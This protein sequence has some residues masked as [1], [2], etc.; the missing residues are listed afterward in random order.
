MAGER[1]KGC[2]PARQIPRTSHRPRTCN[3]YSSSPVPCSCSRDCC[4]RGLGRLPL[5]RLPGDLLIDRPGLKIFIPITTMLHRERR[6]ERHPVAVP[7]LGFAQLAG[8]GPWNCETSVTRDGR[9][10]RSARGLVANRGVAQSRRRRR[11]ARGPGSGPHAYRHGRDVRI[12]RLGAVHREAIRGRRAEVFLV[13]KVLPSNAS[14]RGTVQA[15]EQSLKNLGTDHLDCYLLH[16]RGPTIR[17]PETVAAF[18][19]LQRDGK[20]RSWGVS[21]FDVAD[22][23]EVTAIAGRARLQPGA[24]PRGGTGDRAR[25][26]CPGAPRT[27]PRSSPTRPSGVRRPSIRRARPADE[28]CSRSPRRTARPPGRWHCDSCCAIRTYL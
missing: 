14:A 6:G 3:A 13:S 4:G 21:N 24:L 15:C 19:N 12:R 18:A 1:L 17:W 8:T 9:W 20:I 10:R 26:H 5:G 7:S 28:S 27:V 23:E 22:L 25:G 2:A 16:W 11:A